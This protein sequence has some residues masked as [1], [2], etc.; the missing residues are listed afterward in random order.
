VLPPVE[1]S[2]LPWCLTHPDHTLA[3]SG[4]Y[5]RIGSG[6]SQPRHLRL[7]SPSKNQTSS[8]L[9]CSALRRLVRLLRPLLSSAAP[10]RR[11]SAPVAPPQKR[12][13]ARQTSQGKTRD[14]HAIHLSHLRLHP[15]GD[16]GLRVLWPPRPNA[17]ALYALPVR[18]AGTL[19]AASFR[20]RIA[21]DTLAVRLA[22]PITRACKGLSPPSHRPDTT[23]GQT[24]PCGTTRH[25]WRTSGRRRDCS[26]RPPTP[27][28]VGFPTRRFLSVS[29][30][31]P[32]CLSPYKRPALSRGFRPLP[33]A[34]GPLA[35]HLLKVIR[36]SVQL[37]QQVQPFAGWSGYYGLCCHPPPH[38]NALRRW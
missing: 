7:L 17:D 32:Q 2:A 23:P 11:L 6:A 19:P 36:K 38:P 27:P 12:G 1:G 4:R 24:V 13:A 5:P 37:L 10:S 28:C 18:Q 9:S 33:P 8:G 16:I 14:L 22:V 15:L 29:A 20:S 30:C 25:A 35:R 26:R 3:A 34:S 21:P 31:G